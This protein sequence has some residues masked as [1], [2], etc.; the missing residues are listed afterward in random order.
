MRAI[1][2]FIVVGALWISPL[3]A[4]AVGQSTPKEQRD[5]IPPVNRQ[6]VARFSGLDKKTL[7]VAGVSQAQRR[8]IRG[9]LDG[10]LERQRPMLL[11][12]RAAWS[13]M[14]ERHNNLK[15]S[16]KRNTFDPCKF[17]TDEALEKTT[18]QIKRARERFYQICRKA[19]DRVLN[20]L[21]ED[22]QAIVK[23]AAD[24][25]PLP[26]PYRW[27]ALSQSQQKTVKRLVEVH[28]ARKALADQYPHLKKKLTTKRLDQR[29][30]QAVG[31]HEAKRLSRLRDKLTKIE[32]DS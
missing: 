12:R 1:Y 23:R 17:V 4:P 22:Q 6:T 13:Q 9:R 8:Q 15:A 27:L 20:V 11:T 28:R 31:E 32:S 19:N 16:A 10:F 3:V 18:K 21:N 14:R 29:V 2:L 5:R 24:N 7:R 30:A 26:A 25:A